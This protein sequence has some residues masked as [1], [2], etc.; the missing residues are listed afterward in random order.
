MAPIQ[1]EVDFDRVEALGVSKIYE[2]HRALSN[3]D[4]RLERGKTTALLGP[5]GAGKTTLLWLFSTLSRP[6]SGEVRFGDLPLKRNKEARG[7]IGL[8]SHASLTYGDLSGLE[9]VAF[10]ARLYGCRFPDREAEQLLQEFGLEDAMRRPVKT[11]SRGMLQRL[12]LARAWVGRPTL[13]LLDEPFTGLDRAST[14]VVIDRIRALQRQ[15]TMTLMVSHDLEITAE[16]ADEALVLVR[17]RTAGR[18]TGPLKPDT[19]RTAYREMV[20]TLIAKRG[21]TE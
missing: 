18:L 16:L 12:G 6:T 19:L 10:F 7:K 13:L 11:Y 9:N 17:G 21:R 14:M 20:E 8:L 15:G 3:V 1:S 4:L 5:N 2:R